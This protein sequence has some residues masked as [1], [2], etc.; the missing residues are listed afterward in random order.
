MLSIVEKELVFDSPKIKI[1]TSNIADRFFISARM[2][3]NGVYD[4]R[5]QAK[6]IG[7]G[8]SLDDLKNLFNYLAKEEL[9]NSLYMDMWITKMK[10]ENEHE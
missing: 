5:R 2:D 6:N 3:N 8:W 1:Y 9:Y 7:P 4:Y 10:K